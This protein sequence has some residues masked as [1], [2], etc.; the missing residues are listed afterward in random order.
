MSNYRG[1][2]FEDKNDDILKIYFERDEMLKSYLKNKKKDIISSIDL[3][4]SQ[5]ILAG[6][7]FDSY[8]NIVPNDIIITE[9]HI[10]ID[11][12]LWN[13]LK[14]CFFFDDRIYLIDFRCNIFF[15]YFE[16]NK[17]ENKEL[18]DYIIKINYSDLY[19]FKFTDPRIYIFT[20]VFTIHDRFKYLFDQEFSKPDSFHKLY[21]LITKSEYLYI[22]NIAKELT[23]QVMRDKEM[24]TGNLIVTHS[25]ILGF[26]KESDFKKNFY[27]DYQNKNYLN[28]YDLNDITINIKDLSELEMSHHYNLY[29]Q[30][31]ISLIL[32]NH[33][34][35][36]NISHRGEKYII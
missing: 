30:D 14:D 35:P 7:G 27:E 25:N 26:N 34:I 15:H 4:N 5:F 8:Q 2:L 23:M 6:K 16:I 17:T 36:L 20:S 1:S 13:S 11:L 33:D 24:R 19:S 9:D 28:K 22:I 10:D 21:S 3:K 29:F 31:M 18:Y 12:E 32:T